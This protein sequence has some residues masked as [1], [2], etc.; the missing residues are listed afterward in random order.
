MFLSDQL[1]GFC[2]T[3]QRL[4]TYKIVNTLPFFPCA[5]HKD[6]FHIT[7]WLWKPV[8]LDGHPD[9]SHSNTSGS[10]NNCTCP[11]IEN[12]HDSFR[13]QGY[14]NVINQGGHPILHWFPWSP[15]SCETRLWLTCVSLL[16]EARFFSSK[17][18]APQGRCPPQ[19]TT[20]CCRSPWN[21]QRSTPR[22][23]SKKAVSLGWRGSLSVCI[24]L[25][26]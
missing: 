7:W 15:R 16:C 21:S 19:S 9:W 25:N 26:C 17:S 11:C 3:T 14:Q 24:D 1:S 12:W 22:R 4:K 13:F 8:Q 6:F 10:L 23:K 18:S 2:L 20:L 5:N